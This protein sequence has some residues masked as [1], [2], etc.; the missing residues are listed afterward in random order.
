L[1]KVAKFLKFRKAREKFDVNPGRRREKQFPTTIGDTK[2]RA[3][4]QLD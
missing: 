2:M 4:R 1:F 3:F